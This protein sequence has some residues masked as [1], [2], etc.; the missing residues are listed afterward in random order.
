[1]QQLKKHRKA[2]LTG[3][4]AVLFAFFGL[5]TSIGMAKAE[6]E[7]PATGWKSGTAN[8]AV[9]NTDLVKLGASA[10]VAN[11]DNVLDSPNNTVYFQMMADKSGAWS[12]M[13]FLN[14][15]AGWDGVTWPG[16]GTA[17][18]ALPHLIF[19]DG[20]SQLYGNSTSTIFGGAA[21]GITNPV[22]SWS[23]NLV[24]VEVHIGTGGTD[25]SYIKVNGDTIKS[26]KNSTTALAHMT[27]AD[28]ANGCYIGFHFNLTP[29][30]ANTIYLGSYNT[31]ITTSIDAT[32][33]NQI[34]MLSD[35]PVA[36]DASFTVTN[37]AD[38]AGAVLKLNGVTVNS[39]YYTKEAVTGDST[40]AKFTIKKEFWKSG[41]T[42]TTASYL[43]VES[44]NGSAA[45]VLDILSDVPPT[46]KGA[47]YKDIEAK[48]DVTFE[49]NY[50][51]D[52]ATLKSRAQ[53]YSGV[54]YGSFDKTNALT[55]DTDYTITEKEAGVYNFTVKAEYL[56]S[57]L[58]SY[59][60]RYFQ[61]KV[62]E[63]TL[64][65]SLFL[66]NEKAGLII[67][68]IDLDDASSL[69]ADDYYTTGKFSKLNTNVLVP[70]AYY[71][72]AVS[73]DK[74][75]FV[76]LDAISGDT[77]WALLQ[78]SDSLKTMD[79]FSNETH[80][81]SMLQALFFGGRN[82][83]QKL[84][85]FT[86]GG[87]TNATYPLSSMKKIAVEIF[88]GE[89]AA[90]GYVKINGTKVGTPTKKQADFAG[91]KAYVGWFFNNNKGATYATLNSN[92]NP[93][94]IESPN[95]ENTESMDDYF[96]MD[97]AKA[98]DFELILKNTAGKLTIKDQ[99]GDTL[100]SDTDYAYNKETGILT[101]KSAYFSDLKF[102]K[103]GLI[104][105][106][107]T[108]SATGTQFK[109]TY[110]T[111][112]MKASQVVFGTVGARE[113]VV[114]TLKDVTE[115]ATVLLADGTDLAAELYTF[116]G[117]ALTIKK[118]AIADKKGITEFMAVSGDSA[119]YPLYVY[120]DAFVD[121]GVKTGTGTGTATVDEDV[122]TF[123]GGLTYTLM[124]AFNLNETLKLA[125][126][127]DT[128]L[129]YYKGG[130]NKTAQYFK[131]S[132]YDPYSGY[133]LVYTLYCNY[134]DAEVT[135]SDTAFYES[136]YV[137]DGEGA[138][139]IATTGRA[140]NISTGENKSASG[141]HTLSIGVSGTNLVIQVDNARSTTISVAHLGIFNLSA[142]VC[143]IETP[144]NTSDA[145]G[146]VKM[147]VNGEFETDTPGPGDGDGD[148]DG[149]NGS[150]DGC[151]S[152]AA[153]ASVFV[154][155]LA[156]AAVALLR[157]KRL[158][159]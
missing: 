6:T 43:T 95:V 57:V 146:I 26:E 50:A 32:F 129:G 51:Y 83:I 37:L 155:L 77:E 97:L 49:F 133:T 14:G 7:A 17:T 41:M 150:D 145:S 27:T 56:E 84:T 115:V 132:F 88:F 24:G 33:N 31:P 36:A 62:G 81:E 70:R 135:A 128:V 156:I 100:S 18:D 131:V 35:T 126:D 106:W 10:I 130:L 151:K 92:I 86:A 72:N 107:D 21:V 1:M 138:Y 22:N 2:Y 147:I 71:N 73:V 5:L 114:F 148:G 104:S 53:V 79:Y 123:D 4:L 116:A 94:V 39:S 48:E 42:F 124:E 76:E 63:H 60:G 98:Q 158:N 121:G 89:N 110:T 125:I 93:V 61:L 40:G 66:K 80:A 82:D 101:I 46:W 59:G 87:S 153:S 44:T 15:T 52:L 12:G 19:Q 141:V 139:V 55:I 25:L 136:Y 28:F 85:G 91:G 108:D 58:T 120:T 103:S 113:D 54:Y 34:N 140:L 127:F 68:D 69:T 157:K 144:A 74:P 102:S 64:G 112:D 29:D 149:G 23:A 118:E 143:S 96:V 119:L 75:I 154:A 65:A 90:D 122:L 111:S 105:I 8:A 67:R 99:N 47:S 20:G 3:M 78:V 109:M 13:S 11:M 152:S 16:I 142:V 9:A 117:G 134:P 159:A 38:Y 137:I 30:S 45:V